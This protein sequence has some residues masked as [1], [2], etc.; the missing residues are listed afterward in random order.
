M[1]YL[2]Y[3][4]G[5]MVIGFLFLFVCIKMNWLNLDNNDH[6]IG[7]AVGI[8]WIWPAFMLLVLILGFPAFVIRKMIR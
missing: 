4:I 2:I 7:M 1:Q 8:F 6:E 3:L 5:Y